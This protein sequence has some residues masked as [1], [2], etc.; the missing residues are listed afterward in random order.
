MGGV[1]NMD[2][3]N[4]NGRLPIWPSQASNLVLI[5]SVSVPAFG[6]K[7]NHVQRDP[8]SWWLSSRPWQRSVL[9]GILC[10]IDEPY[11]PQVANL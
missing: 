11:E 3:G 7:Y 4:R 6:T 1:R 9:V 10:A 2:L 5:P 8:G